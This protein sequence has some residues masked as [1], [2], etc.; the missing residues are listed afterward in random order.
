MSTHD[1]KAT[2]QIAAND[3]AFH[4][5]RR[6]ESAAKENVGTNGSTG[7]TAASD[8]DTRK[9]VLTFIRDKTGS[10]M[11]HKDFTLPQ[12]RD[13]ILKGN[14]DSKDKLLW[15]KGA[16]FGRFKSNRGSYRTNINVNLLTAVMAEYDKPQNGVE[17]AISFDEAVTIIKKAR[18][19]ALLYT[20]PSHKEGK[21][22]WRIIFPLS[23]YIDNPKVRHEVLVAMING[24]FNSQIAPESF[25]LSQAYYFGSVNN[26]PDHRCEIVDGDFLDLRDDLFAGRKFKSGHDEAVGIPSKGNASGHKTQQER[27]EDNV[28][29]VDKVIDA[30]DA[31]TNNNVDELTWHRLI[32]SA[33]NGSDGAP[34]ALAA[35][36]RWSA[37][38]PKKHKPE[39]NDY[40]WDAFFDSPPT[41]IGVGT[42]YFFANETAPG[43]WERAV[44][45]AE[46][47]MTAAYADLIKARRYGKGGQSNV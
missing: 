29:N 12:W 14:A 26:N 8:I 20:S 41:E 9:V 39:R 19:R 31:S 2:D 35:F 23:V 10:R 32:A 44:A 5:R 33:W 24:L 27:D 40:R 38:A 28:I 7:S 45:A 15:L 4:E 22:R 11:W 34:E 42:L 47:K 13:I 37:K 16:I 1:P 25:T 3:T 36:Q 30:L 46:V 18:L 43:W 6:A 17:K 21:P